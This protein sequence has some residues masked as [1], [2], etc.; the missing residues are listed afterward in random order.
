MN[1][2]TQNRGFTLIELLVVIAIIAILAAILFPVFAQAKS[3]A[4]KTASLSNQKQIGTAN[5][6]YAGDYDDTLPETGWNGVCSFPGTTQANNDQWS[7]VH[8]FLTGIQ[9]YMKNW[10]IIACPSDADKGVFGKPGELC[11]EY[12]MLDANVPGAYVGMSDVDFGKEM[13]RILPASY[14]GNYLLMNS[15]N[16][17]SLGGWSGQRGRVMTTLESPANIFYSTDVGS[18]TYN[19]LNFAG[20]Y[21][22]PGYGNNGDGSGRW[23]KGAR[24]TGGR[25]WT[26]ADGHAKY[27]KDPDYVNADGSTKSRRQ[28]VW[29]YQQRGIWTYW[30]TSSDDYCQY[31]TAEDGCSRYTAGS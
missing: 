10:D 25:N 18:A 15:Y 6:L 2:Q 24:H 12:L 9:P 23:E 27:H 26:F 22:I 29:E 21:I 19:D 5:I 31:P 28:L 30:E 16:P 8:P 1:K 7:G 20:W 11:F 3:A 4:K 14:A 13:A 17:A